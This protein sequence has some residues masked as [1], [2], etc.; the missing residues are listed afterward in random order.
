MFSAT[1]LNISAKT[2]EFLMLSLSLVLSPKDL[3]LSWSKLLIFQLL[4]PSLSFALL[5]Y[6]LKDSMY[7][8]ILLSQ[9]MMLRSKSMLLMQRSLDQLSI[10]FSV[11]VTLT[12]E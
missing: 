10:L 5:N 2:R 4:S 6:K 3:R 1:S 11:K 7:L 12:E 9:P 8:T